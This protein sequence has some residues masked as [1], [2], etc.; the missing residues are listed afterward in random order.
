[1][2]FVTEMEIT[3]MSDKTLSHHQRALEL[4]KVLAML[5][6][7]APCEDCARLALEMRQTAG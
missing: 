3:Y 4:P 7:E 5:A 1:M 2:E 6:K